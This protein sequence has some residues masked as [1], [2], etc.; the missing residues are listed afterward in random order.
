MVHEPDEP[1]EL[2]V[3]NTDN[4]DVEHEQTDID[5]R[6]LALATGGLLVVA[7]VA[8]LLLFV[9]FNYFQ[10]REAGLV[11][12]RY[13]L[14]AGKTRMP[15]EPRLQPN[16]G[17]DMKEL[18]RRQEQILRSYGWVDETAGVVRIPIDEAMRL[19]VERGLPAR[20]GVPPYVG[21]R[22]ASGSSS[23]RPTEGK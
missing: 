11:D 16:P 19:V 13:P 5:F 1:R 23:G 21:D 3:S 17:E 15:P 12:P 2:S 8:H 14:A 6:A 9:L 4:P 18:R 20:P 22:P 10:G 7:L